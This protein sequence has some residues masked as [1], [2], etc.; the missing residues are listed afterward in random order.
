[1]QELISIIIPVYNM[2]QYLNRCLE[3]I[4]NQTYSNLEIILVDDGSKDSSGKICDEYAAEDSR[5]KVIHQENGGLSAARNRGL[6]I[7]KG[8]LIGFVDA[9]D[10]ILEDMYMYL[11]RLMEEYHADI[12]MCGL[13][14]NPSHFGMDEPEHIEVLSGEKL[15]RYFYRQDGQPSCYSVWNRLY[16][17]SAVEG[18]AFLEGRT[19]ED[20]LY[21]FE[22]YR[23]IQKA[24]WSNQRKYLYF[25]NPNGITRSGLCRKDFSLIE[26]WDRIV[27]MEDNPVYKD[28]AVQNRARAAFTLYVKG[29]RY[30]REK[31]ISSTVMNAWKKEIRENKEILMRGKF[32][33]WKRKLLLKFI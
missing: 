22:A 20:V 33:D 10:W 13:T 1:M 16:R 14:R 8:E 2:E 25:V 7:A 30:G 4:V 17:K 12:S 28:W 18:I 19:T 32:L 6:A 26:I 23:R 11:H 9:D 5:I 27:D 21:T 15:W 29:K 24:V 3:S 31:E